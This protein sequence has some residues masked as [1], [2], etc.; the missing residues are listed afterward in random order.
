MDAMDGWIYCNRDIIGLCT[1]QRPIIGEVE[2]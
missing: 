1:P 2:N